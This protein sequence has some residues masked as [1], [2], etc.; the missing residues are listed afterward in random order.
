V[1]S[2]NIGSPLVFSAN[3]KLDQALGQGIDA[4]EAEVAEHGALATARWL[5]QR[6]VEA[7]LNQEL[8]LEAIEYLLTSERTDDHML[9]R[10]ELAEMMQPGDMTLADLLWF[11][12][13]DTAVELGDADMIAEASSH[14]AEIAFEVEEPTTAAEVWIDFLN[15]RREPESSSDADTVLTAFDEIIRAA[16]MDGAQADAARFGYLQVQFQALVDAE[17]ERATAGNWMPSDAPIEVWQ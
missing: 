15:W 10:A 4:W 8:L 1:R 13:R 7:R 5:T 16:E 14:I 2:Q 3:P 9:A 17:D 12:V 11:A 6:S